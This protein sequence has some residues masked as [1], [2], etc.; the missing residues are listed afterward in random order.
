MSSSKKKKAA[1]A[2]HSTSAPAWVLATSDNFMPAAVGQDQLSSSVLV[3]SDT[4]LSGSFIHES[5]LTTDLGVMSSG[6][7]G[8]LPKCLADRSLLLQASAMEAMG[9]A[10]GDSVLVR[11]IGSDLKAVLRVWAAGDSQAQV[12]TVTH[13]A[14]ATLQ[15][16][17]DGCCQVSV[18]KFEGKPFFPT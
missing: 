15:I 18:T 1:A 3:P 14:G 11:A 4:S 5:A 2:L 17:A 13:Q 6:N 12:A 10:G 7:L 16:G 8:G 9:L